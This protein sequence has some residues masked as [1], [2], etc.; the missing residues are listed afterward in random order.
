[1]KPIHFILGASILCVGLSACRKEQS[2]ADKQREIE[3]GKL[4]ETMTYTADE[5]GWST[6]L[7]AD[8]DVMSK[9][10]TQGLQ[11]KGQQMIE[12]AAEGA[13]DVSKL[14][15]L[16]NLRKDQFNTLLSTIEPYD[17]TADG[18]WVEAH[19]GIIELIT[20]SYAQ[21]GVKMGQTKSGVEMLDGLEFQTWEA[22][23]LH[24]SGKSVLIVQKM[25]SR[26][27]HGYDFAVTLTTNN[28]KDRE[29]LTKMVQ[30]FKFSKRP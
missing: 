25:Y 21:A 5:I 1:M 22:E 11:E 28:E 12:K 2:L 16:L 7:P 9:K 27:I 6:T 8:W 14:K 26:L 4:D 15:Q 30:A 23:V 13:V 17:E 10:A 24:P 20:G 29:T 18:P 19:K 3:T